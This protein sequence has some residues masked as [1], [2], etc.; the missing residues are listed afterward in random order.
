MVQAKTT[1]NEEPVARLSRDVI[2]VM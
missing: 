1:L 2:E